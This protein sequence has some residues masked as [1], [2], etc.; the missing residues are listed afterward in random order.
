[1]YAVFTNKTAESAK[2]ES[3]SVIFTTKGSKLGDLCKQTID[4][5]FHKV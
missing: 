3:I 5:H 1:M 4:F 2:N